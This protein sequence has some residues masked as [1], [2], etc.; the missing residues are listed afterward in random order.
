LRDGWYLV[1]AA[2]GRLDLD[3]PAGAPLD[4]PELTRTDK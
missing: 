4:P 3:E 2:V 1:R